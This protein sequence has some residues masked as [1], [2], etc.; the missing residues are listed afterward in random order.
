MRRSR[1]S[2]DCLGWVA[3]CRISSTAT[4]SPI[5]TSAHFGTSGGATAIAWPSASC[6]G[7]CGRFMDCARPTGPSAGWP[8]PRTG[9]RAPT[10][11][12][13]WT[14]GF[15]RQNPDRPR[16]RHYSGTSPPV[17]STGRPTGHFAPAVF[18]RPNLCWAP[19]G[20]TTSP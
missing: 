5:V 1:R 4:N 9:C 8:W 7:T 12:P 19:V 10:S 16:R 13:G 6:Q 2:P 20:C 15:A 17:T 14:T 3:C 11:S 18:P